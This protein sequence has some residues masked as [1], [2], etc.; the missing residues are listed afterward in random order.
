MEKGKMY[1]TQITKKDLDEL[2]NVT[3]AYGGDGIDVFRNDDGLEIAVDKMQIERW[4]R[5]VM[6]GGHLM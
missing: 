1:V 2:A 5:T 3:N 4:I 6:S